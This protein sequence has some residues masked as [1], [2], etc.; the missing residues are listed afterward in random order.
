MNG[1]IIEL[2]GL[3][4]TYGTLTAVDHLNLRIKKGEVFGLL[5]PNGAGKSTTIMM[6]LGLTEPDSGSVEVCGF[7]AVTNQIEVKRKVGYLPD[8]VGFYENRSGFE[9]LL[10]TAQLN[11]IPLIT[12]RERAR[13]LLKQ[14]GL[15]KEGHKNAGTYSRGMRQ[16]L[17]LA[18]VLIKNPEVIILDEPTLGIDP[19]GVREFLLLIVQLSRREG[20]TV[21][22]SSHHLHQ[23]QQICDR[24][25][26]FVA[27]KLLAEGDMATLSEKLFTGEPFV[28]EAGVNMAQIQAG[29]SGNGI[30]SGSRLQEALQ[31]VAGVSSIQFT[32]GIF[33]LG[34]SVDATAA[35]ARTV[36]ES[37]FDLIY[38]QKKEYGL[39]DIYNRYFERSEEHEQI[40]QQHPV[41]ERP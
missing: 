30:I 19:R 25:G 14:V 8:E 28:I 32:N 7:D 20:I 34:S 16:R 36:V 3:T 40:A 15:E 11:R 17:G 6:M 24:V 38:L 13:Q 35:I 39:D 18:D 2:S 12:A 9:N 37:G 5:G 10:Y 26:I 22:L 1:N 4:K 41:A 29:E 33:R 23:V 31:Q 21:L 27:G